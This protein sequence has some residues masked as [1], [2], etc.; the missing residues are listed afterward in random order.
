MSPATKPQSDGQLSLFEQSKEE[1]PNRSDAEC[2]R[3]VAQRLIDQFAL[4]P[5]V[6]ERIVASAMGIRGLHRSE[7]PWAGCLLSENGEIII[8]IRRSDSRGRQRFTA[9][10]EIAHTFLPGFRLAP[11]FRCDPGPQA[12]AITPEENLC[13]IAAAELLFPRPHMQADVR[14]ASFDIA[15]INSLRHRYDASL[16]ATAIQFVNHWPEDALLVVLEVRQKPSEMGTRAIPKLRVRYAHASGRW[17]FIPR[18]KSVAI[19]SRLATALHGLPVSGESSLDGLVDPSL[20]TAELAAQ[21]CPF[22]DRRGTETRRVV[23]IYRKAGRSV[24]ENRN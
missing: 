8:K 16:E 10:H 3:S 21:S 14:A 11:Q 4:V 12:A 5:P 9:F 17:P 1:T 15:S 19:D 22:V 7:I 18:H 24:R 2:I 20:V 13:D 6:D 23:A